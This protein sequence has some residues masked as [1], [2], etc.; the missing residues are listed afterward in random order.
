VSEIER[1]G[2][3]LLVG[4]PNTDRRLAEKILVQGGLAVATATVPDILAMPD[5]TPPLIVILDDSGSHEDRMGQLKSLQEHPALQG[6]PVLIL[7]NDKGIESYTTA[8]TK[9]AAAYLVKPVFEE[10][11]LEVVQRLS[12]WSGNSDHTERRRRLR[13]PVVMRVTIDIRKSKHKVP[14]TLVDVSSGGCRVEIKEP[15]EAGDL[16]RVILNAHDETTHVALG[17]EVRWC[18]EPS[19]GIH[20]AGVK[21]T[22]TT[23]MLAGKILGFVSSGLT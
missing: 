8:I 9:G 3:T 4:E 18:S 22:G 5:L 7:A 19:E 14:G 17:G 1:E 23:A 11:L 20:V 13:R 2:F 10:E 15:V 6:V 16:V 12:G 21:F